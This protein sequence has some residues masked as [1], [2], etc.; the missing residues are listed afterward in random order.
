[1]GSNKMKIKNHSLDIIDDEY[2]DFTI[3]SITSTES[4]YQIISKLNYC[5]N[6]DF[7]ISQL[8][9]FTHEEGEQFYFPLYS[10][11]H[12]ELSIDFYIVAN[13][14]SFQ[15]K[16]SIKLNETLDLFFGDVQRTTQLIP[17][18]EQTDYFLIL[19]GDNRHKHSY[20]IFETIKN[21]F[22]NVTEIYLEDLKGLKSRMN[23]IF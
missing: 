5:L 8:L 10:F 1:M 19:K 14:T 12:E 21:K 23:L 22:I 4:A 7:Q 18:L 11:L 3:F 15:P 16:E 13:Q 17:E 9:D 2:F 6:I 20:D